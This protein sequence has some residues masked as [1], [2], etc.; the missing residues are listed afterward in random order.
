MSAIK[1]S[2]YYKIVNGPSWTEAES[3]AVALGGHLVSINDAEED[4]FVWE[5]LGKTAS[6]KGGEHNAYEA[7]HVFIGATDIDSKGTWKWLDGSNMSYSNWTPGEPSNTNSENYVVYQAVNGVDG[8]GTY[9]G[10]WNNARD[11]YYKD[12][13]VDSHIYGIAEVPLSYFSISDLTIT[14]GNSGNIT[15][16]RT[17]GS[18][19][20]QV[21]NLVSS[22]GTATAG[23]DYTAI[24]TTIS[25][26]KGETS[27]TFSVS[28]T[29]D[30]SIE[31]NETFLLSLTASTTDDV[32]AQITD[33]SATITITDDDPEGI[34]KGSS[35][36]KIVNGP[37]NRVIVL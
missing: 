31:L 22:F 34:I 8:Q 1:G 36:Y 19:S 7:N 18:N 23:S 12:Q 4:N 32:P 27:K 16:S 3:N 37:S 24:N 6:Y 15:I 17:G 33:G 5:N 14:E 20:T 28:T 10:K 13:L 2:S 9:A 26:A 21:V 25:F 11:E 30:T 35:Y 29:E